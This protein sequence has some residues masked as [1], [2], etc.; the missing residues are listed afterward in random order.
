MKTKMANCWACKST[1]EFQLH[2][3]VFINGSENFVWVCSKCRIRNPGHDQGMYI[4]A[5]L[6]RQHLDDE[7]IASLPRILPTF[8]NRCSRCGNRGAESH[9]W[10]P[11]GIFGSEEASKWPQDYLCK[12][13][14]DEWH[15]LVTPQLVKSLTYGQPVHPSSHGEE[16]C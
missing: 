3:E 14:H 2:V 8:Y 7:E 11:T 12:R 13:C 10:A 1:T 5:E 9:H 16:D 4:K 6:V 15:R